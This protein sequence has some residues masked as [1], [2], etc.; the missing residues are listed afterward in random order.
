MAAIK[1]GT[2]LSDMKPVMYD[3]EI[4]TGGYVT[5]VSSLHCER[6]EQ[7]ATSTGMDKIEYY[8]NEKGE[9]F[10]FHY[11]HMLNL[12]E[13]ICA[14]DYFPDYTQKEVNKISGVLME[15]IKKHR[16]LRTVL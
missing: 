1:V 14:I 6:L 8:F 7:F 15:A 11:A 2:L 13:S 5:A 16:T 12:Q 10:T 3:L 4:I 9:I